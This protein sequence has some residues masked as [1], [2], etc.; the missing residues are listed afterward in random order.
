MYNK[1]YVISP[2]FPNTHLLP[3]SWSQVRL[4]LQSLACIAPRG[5]E[6]ER[7]ERW[8]E[9][10]CCYVLWVSPIW[11]IHGQAD[12]EGWHSNVVC[13]SAQWNYLGSLKSTVEK[14]LCA[15][16]QPYC[17][18]SHITIC[19]EADSR[20]CLTE[21]LWAVIWAALVSKPHAFQLHPFHKVTA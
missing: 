6:G 14:C 18:S 7:R 11:R 16:Q 3:K 4:E 13:R 8:E 9:S 20:L 2:P 10:F 21:T 17:K 1:P 15:L 19:R 5:R 12:F